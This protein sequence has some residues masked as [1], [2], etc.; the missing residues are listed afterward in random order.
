VQGLDE[1]SRVE[2]LA[3]MLGGPRG[4]ARRRSAQEMYDETLTIKRT[5]SQHE[6]TKT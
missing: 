1:Q 2:E 4:K 6:D 5:D 3:A